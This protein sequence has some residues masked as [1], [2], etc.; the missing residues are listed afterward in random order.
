M[1]VGQ[2]SSGMQ[3]MN[4]ALAALVGRRA[5]TAEEAMARSADPAELQQL[6]ESVGTSTAPH[7]R[8]TRPDRA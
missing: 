4:Q 1:Q 7:A 2:S 5:V 6:L 8:I 3:T